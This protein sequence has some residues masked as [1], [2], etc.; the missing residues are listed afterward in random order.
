MKKSFLLALAA[1]LGV[2][3]T[4]MADT[5]PW[6]WLERVEGANALAWAQGQNER[7]LDEI[8]A[9]P[10][11]EPVHQRALEI[12]TSDERIDYPG[13]I[14]GEVYNFWRDDKHVRG[15]WRKTSLESYSSG[16]PD[17]DV[18]IDLDELADQEDKNW[19]WAGASCRHPDYD[20]CIV[21]LSIGGADAAVSREFDLNTRDFVEGG[22]VLDESKSALAW[23]DLDSAFVGPA[24]EDGDVTDSGYPRTVRLW[25]RGTDLSDAVTVFEGERSDVA[26]RGMRIHDGDEHFDVIVRSPGFFTR[27]YHLY[28]DDQVQRI[29][30]PDDAQLVGVI[31][32]QLLIALKSDWTVNGKTY[33]Q[34]ALVASDL[35]EFLEPEPAFE[36]LLQPGER[37][38]VN[39]VSTTE[40]VVLVNLLDNVRGRLLSFVHD[41][42][43]W[44][45]DEIEVPEMGSVGVVSTDDKS[46]RFFYT[47]T[48][49]LTPATLY[50]ADAASGT[51]TKVRAEPAWFDS[52]GMDV[53]QHE[54][55][56]ADGEMIPY[57][58]VTP[59]NFEA[60]GS[61]PTLLTAYGGFE[62]ARTPYYSG[63]T[64]SAWLEQGGVLVLAN[65]RGGGEFGPRWHHAAL[66]ENRQ[67]AYDDLIAVSEDLVARNI[68]SPQHLGI[69]GGSNG[70]LLVGAVMVQRPDLFNAVVCQ[71]PLLDM[72]R[73]HKL[74]AGASWMGEY[75]NPDD[76]EQWAYISK[77]S[78][79]QNV[80]EDAEYPRALF[81][82]ST[83]D[84]RVHPGHA[85]KMVAR[86]LD[87]GH[88]VLYYENIEGGH[89]GAANLKQQ[90]FLSGLVYAYLHER[91]GPTDED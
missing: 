64:G 48:G 42:D 36:V 70:G 69:Q 27:E 9:H 8:R 66:K 40:N 73:F 61:N 18:I 11:F 87:Q 62:I 53:V 37:Q 76:P 4:A 26:V 68:T 29:H 54:A 10:Q 85:R 5:D 38:A 41:E 60:D 13:L 71:V 90:A 43:G 80:R 34:G 31:D 63:V 56:S 7:S 51:S 57:F 58:V 22:F 86:M 35:S 47:F 15:I 79:Y 89:G 3:L 75:G 84:D 52:E 65:I 25:R 17:W 1:G 55:Q 74:L 32:G 78:P 2:S 91:L 72:K 77:Y 14:N 12:L 44:H 30:V 50:E 16:R 33:P 28:T 21:S 20:R 19:V 39:G 49:F 23:R 45:Q 81:T 83:R 82:T 67:R 88:D 59:P 46:D 24:F 6:L